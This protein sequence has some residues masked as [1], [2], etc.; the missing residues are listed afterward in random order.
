MGRSFYSDE[1]ETYSVPGLPTV[2][3]IEES[4]TPASAVEPSSASITINKFGNLITTSTGL[5]NFVSKIRMTTQDYIGVFNEKYLYYTG[6]AQAHLGMTVARIYDFKGE[7]EQLL[8]NGCGVLTATLLG[9]IV[10]RTR[11]FP[12]RFFTPILFGG[13]ALKY[14]LPQT[15]QNV[16]DGFKNVGLKVE[17]KY[18]PEFAKTR[19]ESSAK[20]SE[21]KTSIQNLQTDSWNCL[22]DTVATT[23]K[24]ICETL[25]KD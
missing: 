25:K 24:T 3:Q 15:Y 20:V 17:A 18:F 22:V 14:A 10:S 5:E 13:I 19:E 1:E 11:S 6:T 9:S 23:R 21:L 12:V 16:A 2:A 4:K 8:P 7:D